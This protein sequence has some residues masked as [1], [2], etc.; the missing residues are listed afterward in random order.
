MQTMGMK[1][2]TQ[3]TFDISKVM[4]SFYPVC[5][6]TFD[7]VMK[8]VAKSLCAVAVSLEHYGGTVLS[9]STSH[10]CWFFPPED[11]VVPVVGGGKRQRDDKTSENHFTAGQGGRVSSDQFIKNRPS[12]Q[13]S[14]PQRLGKMEIT[15]DEE[16]GEQREETF[17]GLEK[18][19]GCGHLRLSDL[20]STCEW[21]SLADAQCSTFVPD[22]IRQCLEGATK[23][24]DSVDRS[25][26]AALETKQSL[27]CVCDA[28]LPKLKAIEMASDL[29]SSLLRVAF[30]VSEK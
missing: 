10:H 7:T 5:T 22:S 19:C 17:F 20:P 26:P 24:S 23:E 14:I 9:D 6:E 11:S 2:A 29:A 13:A 3:M 27:A 12:Y 15:T 1:W 4:V 21:T 25:S 16:R 28:F 18:T 30:S 8:S